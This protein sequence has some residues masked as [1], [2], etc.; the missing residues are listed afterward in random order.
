[1]KIKPIRHENSISSSIVIPTTPS[2][3]TGIKLRPQASNKT[4]VDILAENLKSMCGKDYSKMLKSNIKSTISQE[5]MPAIFNNDSPSNIKYSMNMINEI[6]FQNK[7]A[8]R[9]QKREFIN[10]SDKK[11][12]ATKYTILTKLHDK[13]KSNLS[14]GKTEFKD[15][16]NETFMD[17]TKFPVIHAN[18]TTDNSKA[19][20][21]YD[22]TKNLISNTQ[23]KGS[24]MNDSRTQQ[25][26]NK[27]V[28]H[29][30]NISRKEVKKEETSS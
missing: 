17:S 23:K 2:E 10:R 9:Y 16:K 20:T 12:A 29:L 13:Y 19:M 21:P 28:I 5:K 30:R 27:A 25:E 11:T 7:T 4:T 22:S 6:I 8:T 15:A 3:F 24:F 18:F 14:R 26:I 1:M